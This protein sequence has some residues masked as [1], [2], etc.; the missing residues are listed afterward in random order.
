MNEKP[1]NTSATS[2]PADG[3]SSAPFVLDFLYHDS[4]RIGS[5]LSQFEG[6]GHLQQLTTTKNGSRGKKETGSR[7]VKGTLGVASGALT[8]STETSLSMAEGYSR[9]LDP[10]WA[11]ARAFLD[12]LSE[13][14]MIQRDLSAADIGQFVLAKGW[15]N[16]LDLA[17][18]KD[19]WKLPAIQRKA[20]AGAVPT[21]PTS[22]MTAAQ[23][24]EIREQKENTEMFLEMIQL[25][26]HSV[27]ASMITSDD[28]PKLV[29][30]SL[31]EEY[32]TTPA[33]DLM[34]AHGARMP[35][36]WSIVGIL[37]A[38]P[39]YIV[40]EF[41]AANDSSV[42]GLMHSMV[43]QMSQ[44]LAPLVRVALGRPAAANAITPLLIF[45]EVT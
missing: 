45:R 25:M 21:T 44:T 13:R 10:Y 38:P 18:M 40:P 6:D 31:R 36:E 42:P 30:C 15:L 19:A 11:N 24:A 27:H 5:F 43:G 20:K 2:D 4:R 22:K 23:K 1:E 34:L 16:I 9:V 28:E 8:G 26:P 14:E 41:E 39:E 7:D 29:W 37:T 35:G 17:M 32:L 3:D 12:Y 33:S